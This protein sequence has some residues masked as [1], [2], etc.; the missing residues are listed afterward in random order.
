MHTKA[1]S[2]WAHACNWLNTQQQPTQTHRRA[3]AHTHTYIFKRAMIKEKKEQKHRIKFYSKRYRRWESGT[4]NAKL[5]PFDNVAIFLISIDTLRQFGG[6]LR[7]EHVLMQLITGYVRHCASSRRKQRHLLGCH[8]RSYCPS[9]VECRDSE[10]TTF[11]V[12]RQGRS[13]RVQI[14]KLSSPGL[15]LMETYHTLRTFTERN[16]VLGIQ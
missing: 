7:H 4:I 14:L 3:Q 9:V 6:N 1:C 15:W 10:R 8:V 12:G 13:I 16:Y 11:L 5:D 2:L